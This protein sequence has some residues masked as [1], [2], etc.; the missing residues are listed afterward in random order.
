M[1]QIKWRRIHWRGL[2]RRKTGRYR[3]LKSHYDNHSHRKSQENFHIN[4]K[5]SMAK[6]INMS[7]L[8]FLQD[9]GS[10]ICSGLF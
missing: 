1:V 7:K 10:W 5:L 2:N 9:L 4:A 6:A 8:Q 3:P